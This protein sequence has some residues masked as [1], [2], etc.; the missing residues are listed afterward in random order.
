MNI[1]NTQINIGPASIPAAAYGDT[2]LTLA[3]RRENERKRNSLRALAA[4]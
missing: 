1:V 2:H 4:F 3:D